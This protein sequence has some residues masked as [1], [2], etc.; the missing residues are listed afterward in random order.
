MRRTKIL[1]TSRFSRTGL[2]ELMANVRKGGID[3]VGVDKLDRLGRSLQ[4]LAQ[5]ISEFESTARRWSRLHGRSI[6][7][8]AILPAIADAYSC[9]SRRILNAVLATAFSGQV[10]ASPSFLVASVKL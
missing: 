3:V 7:A 9:C 8:K 10:L 5:L 2:D 6:A 4:Q 1:R